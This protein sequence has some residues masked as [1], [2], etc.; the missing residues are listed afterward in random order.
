[1]IYYYQDGNDNKRSFPDNVLNC[2]VKTIGKRKHPIGLA[3][4]FLFT[5]CNRFARH[6]RKFNYRNLQRIL[7]QMFPRWGHVTPCSSPKIKSSIAPRSVHG[8]ITRVARLHRLNVAKTYPFG[9]PN[10]IRPCPPRS[11]SVTFQHSSHDGWNVS[12]LS[13]HVSANPRSLEYYDNFRSVR[14]H[15]I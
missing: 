13:I 12:F 15:R 5:S 14:F 3:F 8:Q 11:A 9:M 7:L 10:L 4:K 1:M 6:F 2:T